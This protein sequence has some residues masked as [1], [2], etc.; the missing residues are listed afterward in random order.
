MSSGCIVAALIHMEI[1]IKWAF[2]RAKICGIPL[3]LTMVTFAHVGMRW[4]G[5]DN[6]KA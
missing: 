3:A 2:F 5:R 4:E 6:E 1:R